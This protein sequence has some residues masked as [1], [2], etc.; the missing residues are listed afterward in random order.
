MSKKEKNAEKINQK[1]MDAIV[2][3]VSAGVGQTLFRCLVMESPQE[4][5]EKFR[6]WL[7]A[8]ENWRVHKGTVWN[9]DGI[10][11]NGT[12]SWGTDVTVC[13]GGHEY[14]F[15]ILQIDR[16]GGRTF[17]AIPIGMVD[18]FT[19][20]PGIDL[21]AG[22]ILLIREMACELSRKRSISEKTQYILHP[23]RPDLKENRAQWDSSELDFQELLRMMKDENFRNLVVVALAVHYR[24]F[25]PGAALPEGIYNFVIPPKGSNSDLWFYTV[26]QALTFVNATGKN[27]AGP[28]T[29]T[30]KEA[31]DLARWRCCH[32]RLAVIRTATGSLLWPLLEEIEEDDQLMRGGGAVPA[33]LP[34]VPIS[35]TRSYLHHPQ[36]MDILLPVEP[37]LAT[38]KQLDL[39]RAG[40]SRLLRRKIAVRAFQI[41]QNRRAQ[42]AAYRTHGFSDW[43]T[44][45][46]EICCAVWFPGP[47]YNSDRGEVIRD[48]QRCQE[49]QRRA[50]SE[51]I[52]RGID[53]LTNPARYP[54]DIIERP[55]SREEWKTA[56]EAGTIA[57]W[58]TPKSGHDTGSTFLAFTADTLKALLTRAGCFEEHYEA[59]LNRCDNLKLLDDRSRTIKLGKDQISAITF[60]IQRP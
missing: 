19:A 31:E 24:S 55:S 4:E 47:E 6:K 17:Y 58:Y 60:S 21:S 37:P 38:E 7:K 13:L 57:F 59:F 8:S 41:W 5:I 50:V 14:R 49:E 23:A 36:A 10:S 28:I 42:P 12:A 33:P 51:T 29:I 32:E 48:T 54:G 15:R 45:L 40:M 35:L 1:V 53:L 3:E 16:L 11:F 56:V 20:L 27:M 43:H 44:V 46:L 52:Q 30:M 9:S 2:S 25:L 34:T 39:L 18:K 22:E 26:L